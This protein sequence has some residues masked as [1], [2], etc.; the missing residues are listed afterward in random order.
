MDAEDGEVG[1]RGEETNVEVDYRGDGQA[2]LARWCVDERSEW[3]IKEGA[4]GRR[5]SAQRLTR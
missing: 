2:L 5:T 3:T 4:R 1:R